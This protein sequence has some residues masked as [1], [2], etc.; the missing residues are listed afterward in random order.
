MTWN[1][2]WLLRQCRGNDLHLGLIWGTTR[3]FV[4]LRRLQCSSCLVTMFL[5][6][7]W[8]S[9]KQ[10]EATYVFDWEYKIALQA[11][12]GYRASSRSEGDV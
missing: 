1:A 9:I 5:G 3:Y 11:M 6:T 12:Q 10:I 2:G 7:L 8:S 4:F